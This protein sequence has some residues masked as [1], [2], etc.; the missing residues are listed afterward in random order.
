MRIETN[1]TG[2][3]VAIRGQG[4]P[5]VL[6][7]GWPHT[8]RV[9]EKVSLP[10]RMVIAPDLRGIG[11]S[12]AVDDGFDAGTGAEDVRGLLDALK[13]PAAEIAAIDAAVPAAFLMAARHPER[14][15]RLVLMEATLPGMAGGFETPP[16]WF[17][18]HAVPGLAES[19]LDGREPEYLG[20]FLRTITDDDVRA[21]FVSAYTGRDRLRR[22]FG[23][24]RAM[25]ANAGLIRAA[26]PLRVPTV[27]I[28]G[29][30]VGER[31]HRQLQPLA[32]DLQGVL[33]ERCGHIVPLDRP[34]AL[35]ELF[36]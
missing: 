27:A 9:W 20:W 28:G 15:T 24:Y 21:A 13:L 11:A 32:D 14:V 8:H 1:G 33:L 17:G 6:L 23:F 2:L 22:G 3:E 35:I 16:W 7:H 10:G 12:D 34:D 31:L 29:D 36:R 25:A 4:R 5:L 18:F 19:V 26:G 30:V